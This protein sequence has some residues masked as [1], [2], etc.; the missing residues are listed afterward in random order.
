MQ[1][2]LLEF[3][4]FP[5]WVLKRKSHPPTIDDKCWSRGRGLCEQ[6]VQLAFAE[7]LETLASEQR[8][9][10]RTRKDGG[11]SRAR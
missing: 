7:A 8:L 11:C 1:R 6:G 3:N 5:R 9:G 2:P 4:S 10:I